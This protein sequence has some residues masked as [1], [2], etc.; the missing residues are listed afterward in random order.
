[1]PK[2]RRHYNPAERQ[3]RGMGFH[4]TAKSQCTERQRDTT[5]LAAVDRVTE[6]LRL[7][8]LSSH[9]SNTVHAYNGSDVELLATDLAVLVDWTATEPLHAEKA[10]FAADHLRER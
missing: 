10:R 4:A 8:A 7:H 1:M 2:D 6:F 5:L 3:L 9:G